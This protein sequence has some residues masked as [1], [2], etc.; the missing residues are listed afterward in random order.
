MHIEETPTPEQLKALRCE[1]GLTQLEAANI[2]GVARR[3]W[4]AWEQT[5]RTGSHRNIHPTKYTLFL[6]FTKNLRR[7]IERR[8]KKRN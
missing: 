2:V 5:T 6:L 7:S 1:L 3:T 8:A 4:E